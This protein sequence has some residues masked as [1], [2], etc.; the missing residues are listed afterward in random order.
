MEARFDRNIRFFG[1][2]GQDRIGSRSLAIIGIGGLGTHVVQQAALLGFSTCWLIDDEVLGLTN[3]NRYVGVHAS[4]LGTP[5][6]ELGAR[7]IQAVNPD[8]VVIKVRDRLQSLAAFDAIR[9]ADIVIGCLDN[10]GARLVCAEVA[11][12]AG[13]PYVD[14]ASD[15]LPD[16]SMR[17]GG[18]IVFSFIG[19]GC[20]VCRGVI[21]PG[22]G[23]STI[24]GAPVAYT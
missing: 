10:D 17:F 15:I 19:D 6:V 1:S 12:A 21:D 3:L 8:A 4:D 13:K 5:K 18:R 2:A 20:I 22:R 16:E 14:L 24:P 11:A 7:I 23:H 9:Q